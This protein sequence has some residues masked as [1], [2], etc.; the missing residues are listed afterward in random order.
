MITI[1]LWIRRGLST[2]RAMLAAAVGA[3]TLTAGSVRADGTGFAVGDHGHILTSFHVV[4]GCWHLQASAGSVVQT[5]RLVGSDPVNDLALIQ[6]ARPFPV[7]AVFRTGRPIRPGDGV[8]VVGY[9]LPGILASE[10]NVTTG[11]VSANAGPGDDPRFLQISAPIQSGNS[12]G[13]L[14]D[15]SGNVVGMIFAKLDALELAQRTGDIPQNINFAIKQQTVQ[16][17]L[18][19]H[20]VPYRRTVS[21]ARHEPA[22][23]G[24][25]A[26]RFTLFIRCL[27]AGAPTRIGFP[28]PLAAPAILTPPH[29]APGPPAAGA[30]AEASRYQPPAVAV[31]SRPALTPQP[32]ATGP[33]PPRRDRPRPAAA[34]PV[35]PAPATPNAAAPPP[36]SHQPVG[37]QPVGHQLAGRQLVGHLAAVIGPTLDDWAIQV[38]AFRSVALAEGAVET[39]G[40]KLPALLTTYEQV[41][42]PVETEDGML[43]RARLGGLDRVRATEACK[44]LKRRGFGCFVVS[45]DM[46][47]D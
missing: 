31:G 33:M 4:E 12:G 29:P 19:S 30:A 17:F 22:D 3:A 35:P 39:A 41:I 46:P 38:G 21:A 47:V 15:S 16:R 43:Y 32:I 26:K 2:G 5:A 20:Q 23:I 8:V 14:M 27:A 24:E 18:D 1:G 34:M 37:H 42:L 25:S 13:P 9:P 40:K 7:S 45:A 6:V 10:A 44:E 28:A 36:G 11:T